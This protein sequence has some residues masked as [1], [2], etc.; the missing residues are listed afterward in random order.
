MASG[1][2]EP[3][4]QATLT[5]TG[6]VARKF[7]VFPVFFF[8]R[9]YFLCPFELWCFRVVLLYALCVCHKNVVIFA[10]DI[11]PDFAP[12]GVHSTEWDDIP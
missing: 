6:L 2:W 11:L 1:G 12:S 8:S 3:C 10:A 7:F 4:L 9:T 5:G